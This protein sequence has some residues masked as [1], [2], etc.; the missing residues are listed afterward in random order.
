VDAQ[1]QFLLNKVSSYSAHLFIFE[2]ANIL[3]GFNKKEPQIIKL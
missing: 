3:I 2:I 1:E